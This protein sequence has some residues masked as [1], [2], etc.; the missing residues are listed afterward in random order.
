MM[1][2]TRKDI[3]IAYA[4]LIVSALV[5]AWTALSMITGASAE[6]NYRSD[7]FQ[8]D[9]DMYHIGV[10]L[11]ENGEPKAW[12]NYLQEGGNNDSTEG[13]WHVNGEAYLLEDLDFKIGQEY[14]EVLTV[15]N[16]GTIDE[17]VRVTIY[18]YWM[19]SD[20][21]NYKELNDDKN[22]ALDPDYIDL[23]LVNLDED[24]WILDEDYT[25]KER[26]VLYYAYPLT[27]SDGQ[28]F[29]P[30]NGTS[31]PFAD[32]FM[33]D[34]EVKTFI[35]QK[36]ETKTVDDRTY[37]TVTN[38]YLYDG[39]YFCLDVEVDGVQINNAKDAIKSAWGRDVSI[40]DDGKLSLD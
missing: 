22:R 6:L 26:T 2:R 5:F 20:I 18:R 14:N 17:Y 7:E 36:K 9:F 34:P 8:P 27:K 35:Y 33:I 3:V 10:T 30:D 23:N 11:N 1:K 13:S 31:V 19:D 4:V 39:K 32:T 29:D 40:A 37:T 16:S 28:Y 12:R 21:Q 15:S 38:Y 25:T 24:H